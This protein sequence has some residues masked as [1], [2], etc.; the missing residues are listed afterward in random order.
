MPKV[1]SYPWSKMSSRTPSDPRE[2]KFFSQVQASMVIQSR[3]NSPPELLTLERT[4]R[5]FGIRGRILF[6]FA[7]QTTTQT[8]QHRIFIYQN[9]RLRNSNR[10]KK[11]SPPKLHS[12]K[13]Y[14]HFTVPSLALGHPS[15]KKE[16]VSGFCSAGRRRR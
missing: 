8:T 11:R 2:S 15:H 10:L 4:E 14:D 13:S 3:P 16:S 7:L 12:T 9:D 5:M 6:T 1:R